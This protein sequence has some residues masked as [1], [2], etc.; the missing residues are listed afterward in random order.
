MKYQAIVIWLYLTTCVGMSVS[1]IRPSCF[2][3]L[4]SSERQKLFELFL[5]GPSMFSVQNRASVLPSLAGVFR[6]AAGRTKEVFLWV[7]RTVDPTEGTVPHC[8]C[9]ALSWL[10]SS[11]LSNSVCVHI[12]PSRTERYVCVHGHVWEKAGS[13]SVIFKYNKY[14]KKISTTKL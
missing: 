8:S 2:L 9:K 11:L 13:K 3:S 6:E 5:L 7:R 12:R 10:L 1:S 4:S 14:I